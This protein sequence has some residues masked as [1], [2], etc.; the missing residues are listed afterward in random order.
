VSQIRNPIVDREY[1]R[2]KKSDGKSAMEALRCVKR[3]LSDIV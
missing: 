1:Y 2:R 3:R